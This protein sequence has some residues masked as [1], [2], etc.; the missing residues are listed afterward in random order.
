LAPHITE[1]LWSRLGHTSSL[2][3]EDFPAVDESLLVDDTVEVPVQINGK[4]RGVITV[5]ADADAEA[6]EAAARAD[7]RI[8]AALDG[9]ETRRVVAVPGR[10]VNFVV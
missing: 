2:A 5:P 9:R 4:L 6:M 8:T 3:W 10:L 1:E 7:A